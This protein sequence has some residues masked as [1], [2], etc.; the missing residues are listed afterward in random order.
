MP[1]ERARFKEDGY[2][3]SDTPHSGKSSGFHEDRLN[4]LIHVGVLENW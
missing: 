3:I 4:T 2:D 1:S